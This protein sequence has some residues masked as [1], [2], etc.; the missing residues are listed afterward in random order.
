MSHS[1]QLS[2]AFCYAF[3]NH[4]REDFI[5]FFDV[6]HATFEPSTA[7]K[8]PTVN[9]KVVGQLVLSLLEE[10]GLNLLDCV[11]IGTDGYAMMVSNNCSAVVEI[12]KKA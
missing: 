6:H 8:E 11:G 4:T 1:S 10:M 12:Q 2:L 5:G 9:R 3:D 7:E